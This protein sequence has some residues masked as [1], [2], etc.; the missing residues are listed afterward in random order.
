M[1][2]KLALISKSECA[3]IGLDLHTS[4]FFFQVSS[5]YA[6]DQPLKGTSCLYVVPEK[7]DLKEANFILSY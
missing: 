6:T 5:Q 1:K 3:P 7:R 2:K 4:F